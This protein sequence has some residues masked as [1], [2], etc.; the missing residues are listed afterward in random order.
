M[1]VCEVCK[2]ELKDEGFISVLGV[3]NSEAHQAVC[4]DYCSPACLHKRCQ[5]VA[6]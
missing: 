3:S 1:R 2:K 5:E 4:G 6:P